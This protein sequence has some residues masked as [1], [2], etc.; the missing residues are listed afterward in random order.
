MYQEMIDHKVV[1][2]SPS[3][4]KAHAAGF[5]RLSMKEKFDDVVF[6]IINMRFYLRL[7]GSDRLKRYFTVLPEPNKST[8]SFDSRTKTEQ[9]QT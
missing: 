8:K 6:H 9:N 4:L 3:G 2:T 1:I 5:F 7:Y